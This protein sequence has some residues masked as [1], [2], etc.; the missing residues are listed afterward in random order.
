[1]SILFELCVSDIVEPVACR[2]AL[3]TNECSIAT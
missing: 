1:M 2:L 3:D